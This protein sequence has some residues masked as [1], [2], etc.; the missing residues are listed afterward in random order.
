MQCNN[1]FNTQQN[2][3]EKYSWPSGA[4]VPEALLIEGGHRVQRFTHH[5]ATHVDSVAH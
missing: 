2:F 5:S 1:P 4:A 3:R